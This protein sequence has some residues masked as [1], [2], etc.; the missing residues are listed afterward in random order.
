MVCGILVPPPGMKPVLL[1]LEAQSLNHW[2]TKYVRCN[3]WLQYLGYMRACTCILCVEQ[4]PG[5][6]KLALG[7]QVESR[8]MELEQLQMCEQPC[9]RMLALP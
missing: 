5:F 1:A 7:L 4:T 3:W 6:I 2:T 9:C 8:N